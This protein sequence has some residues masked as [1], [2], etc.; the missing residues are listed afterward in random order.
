M[1]IISCWAISSVS[2]PI[3]TD[4]WTISR[5]ISRVQLC[6]PKFIVYELFSYA[7]LYSS[8]SMYRHVIS[9]VINYFFVIGKCGKLSLPRGRTR[10]L[11]MFPLN[12]TAK[13]FV[14]HR[15]KATSSV[16]FSGR[17]ARIQTNWR[18]MLMRKSNCQTSCFTK[19]MPSKYKSHF[20]NYRIRITR[21]FTWLQMSL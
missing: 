20:T 4:W 18:S 7:D 6:S 21:I 13:T 11:F 16:F 10:F 15:S 19:T 2:I 9:V 12:C 8:R 1:A 5:S 3:N 14:S 17:R